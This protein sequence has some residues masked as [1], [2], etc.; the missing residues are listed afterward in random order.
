MAEEIETEEPHCYH[1]AKKDKQWGKW[2]G[3][4]KEEIDSLT[5]NETWYIVDRPKT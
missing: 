3:G 2:N 5:K 4:I 1:D